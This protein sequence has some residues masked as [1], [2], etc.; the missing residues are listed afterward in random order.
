MFNSAALGNLHR[1]PPPLPPLVRLRKR[2]RSPGVLPVRRALGVER[3]HATDKKRQHSHHHE[4]SHRLK[5]RGHGSTI[6]SDAILPR[7]I[8]SFA[9]SAPAAFNVRCRRLLPLGRP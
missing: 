1:V 7:N 5:L 4:E 8:S 2:A 3:S 9:L 6:Q